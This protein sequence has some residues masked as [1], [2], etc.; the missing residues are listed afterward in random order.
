MKKSSGNRKKK[1]V[2][3]PPALN[4]GMRESNHIDYESIFRDS[5]DAFIIISAINGKLIEA[6]KGALSLLGYKTEELLKLAA[7]DIFSDQEYLLLRQNYLGDSP[8]FN[9]TFLNSEFI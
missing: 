7:K 4:N 9:E 2:I 3:T 1:I 6:N 8:S 5:V